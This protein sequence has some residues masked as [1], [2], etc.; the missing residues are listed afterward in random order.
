MVAIV[1][2]SR[3]FEPKANEKWTLVKDLKR[4]RKNERPT[5]ATLSF[6]GVD[7]TI[8]FPVHWD[9]KSSP[10]IDARNMF[11]QTG[12]MS[13]RDD[14]FASTAAVQSAITHIDGDKGKLQYRGYKIEDLAEKSNFPEVMYLLLKGKM[15]SQSQ[16]KKFKADLKGQGALP[17]ALEAA[18]KQAPDSAHPMQ[19][20]ASMVNFLGSFHPDSQDERDLEQVQK[21]SMVLLSSLPD[22]AARIYRHKHG[23]GDVP[24]DMPGNLSYTGRFLYQAFGK[25]LSNNEELPAKFAEE[26]FDKLFILHADHEQNC[27]T[28]TVR[29]I[30]SS[31][32]DTYAAISGGVNALSGP[33]H[34]MANQDV[35]ENLNKI[36]KEIDEKVQ[37]G[38]TFD[39]HMET[40]LDGVIE[41]ALL[42]G[43]QKTLIP[44]S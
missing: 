44:G 22:I 30:G 19:I 34:G 39:E 18:I 36:Q 15:P 12:G 23:K 21:D 8:K 6:E 33:A 31:K 32:A 13:V 17:E 3:A 9:K 38:G 41:K 11:R 16:L 40:V 37:Q 24:A 7:H 28:S 4:L 25:S 5:E 14:G 10:T 29:M 42:P 1:E 26:I 2:G 27:S 20:L 35:L 43:E